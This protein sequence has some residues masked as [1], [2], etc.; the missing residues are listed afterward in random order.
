MHI[1]YRLA[2]KLGLTWSPSRAW[3][4]RSGYSWLG[5]KVRRLPDFDWHTAVAAGYD[6][7]VRDA[8]EQLKDPN[9]PAN[10]VRREID[11]LERPYRGV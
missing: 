4:G 6:E 5:R 2:W 10:L 7:G 1:I 8:N 11:K 9:H 3:S